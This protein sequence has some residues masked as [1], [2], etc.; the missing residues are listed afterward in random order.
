MI[1][2]YTNL[3]NTYKE[4]LTLCFH[5][6]PELRRQVISGMFRYTYDVKVEKITVAQPWHKLLFCR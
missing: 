3:L 4:E 1:I 6:F 5:L 2:L